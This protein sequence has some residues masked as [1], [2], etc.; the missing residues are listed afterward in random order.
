M[1]LVRR[2][3]QGGGI[4]ESIDNSLNNLGTLGKLMVEAIDPTGLQ[5]GKT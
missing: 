5:A 3:N 2:F 4:A 1:K